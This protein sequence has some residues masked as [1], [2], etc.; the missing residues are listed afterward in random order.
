MKSHVTDFALNSYVKMI[1][2]ATADELRTSM[3]EKESSFDFTIL[4]PSGVSNAIKTCTNP[5]I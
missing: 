5:E 1:C 2:Y 4:D 3:V